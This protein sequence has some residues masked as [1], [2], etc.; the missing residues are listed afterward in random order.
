MPESP[1]R[2]FLKLALGGA[3]A[4]AAAGA[5][6]SR[7]G[8]ARSARRLP[9][10]ADS[11]LDM[12]RELAKTP[13]KAPSAA[14]PDAFAKL[15]SEQYLA[16]R[17]NPDTA[18]W[19]DDKIGFALEPLHRGFIFTAPVDIYR[20]RE[21]PS[22]PPRL[23]PQRLRLRQVAAARR[24]AGDIGFSGVRVLRA[25]DDQGWR[26]FAIFQGA[27]FFRSLARGQTYGLNARGLSIRTGDAAGRGI[28][29]V[30]RAVDREAEPGGR[31]ADDPRA[32]RFGE[33]DRRISLHAA[34]G[35]RDDHRHRIDAVA[36][37]SRSTTSAS[38]R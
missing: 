5:G 35:R 30:S 2:D 1:R 8:R 34:S 4:A 28:S 31:C 13:F 14:L 23:R 29:A 17:H 7:L 24:Y 27:T 25:G 11:L 26:E 10:S 18:V 3:F 38:A 16:I 21:R 20:R 15:T 9:F 33:R 19:S 6:A 36:R 32:A 12:A 37:A 22:A